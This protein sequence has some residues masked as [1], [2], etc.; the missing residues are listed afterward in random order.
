MMLFSFFASG[1]LLFYWVENALAF[2]VGNQILASKSLNESNLIFF[3]LVNQ[4]MGSGAG[5]RPPPLE[6][7]LTNTTISK[8]LTQISS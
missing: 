6:Q 7:V 4:I 5:E 1:S 8:L 2:C 3:F